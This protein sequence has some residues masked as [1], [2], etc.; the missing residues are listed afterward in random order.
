MI[1]WTRLTGEQVESIVALLINREHPKSVRVKPS[2]GDGGIDIILPEEEGQRGPIV[3]QVKKFTDPLTASQKK[4]IAESLNSLSKDSRWKDLSIEEWHLVIPLDPTPEALNWFIEVTK[5]CPF[6]TYWLGLSYIENLVSKYPD[7]PDYLIDG[8]REELSKKQKELMALITPDSP[9]KPVNFGNYLPKL[10]SAVEALQGDPYYHFGFRSGYGKPP[11]EYEQEGVVFSYIVSDTNGSKRWVAVDVIALCEESTRLSPIKIQGVLNVEKGS[12][13]EESVNDFVRFGKPVESVPFF[14]IIKAPGGLGGEI[15]EGRA[16]FETSFRVNSEHDELKMDAINANGEVLA[17]LDLD[18]I[19]LTTGDKGLR[20]LFA[21]PHRVLEIELRS[22]KSD[23]RQLDIS[24]STPKTEE[25]PVLRVRPVVEFLYF[26]QQSTS[27]RLG[28]RDAWPASAS[29]S[30][31]LTQAFRHESIRK[32]VNSLHA[33]VSALCRIQKHTSTVI[34]SPA[35]S[36]VTRR[37]FEIWNNVARILEG[38]QVRATY[39]ESK[40]LV[41]LPKNVE[42]VS[43]DLCLSI[44]FSVMVQDQII[45]LGT[46]GILLEDPTIISTH[47]SLDSYIY[48]VSTPDRSFSYISPDSYQ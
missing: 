43:G 39:P 22:L 13:L 46:T 36:K 7:I 33:W 23:L 18:R 47:V 5:N 27:V 30:T 2:R 12:P 42:Y 31:S 35:I 16:S 37:D 1:E 10:R 38:E 41:Q 19:D 25:K 34:I 11:L 44:P 9:A 26:C 14:G 24:W 6:K 20:T 15:S 32:E 8:R 29:E 21:D 40:L 4:K 28:Q 48:E 3:F 45:P 17:E